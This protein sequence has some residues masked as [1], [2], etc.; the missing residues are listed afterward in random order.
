MLRRSPAQRKPGTDRRPSRERLPRAALVDE[1]N[2]LAGEA[3][4]LYRAAEMPAELASVEM[5]LA[6][7]YSN[8]GD[9]EWADE[10][11]AD[12]E[13][14]L[15]AIEPAPHVTALKSFVR[16]RRLM[17][18]D[19]FDYADDAFR[20]AAEQLEAAEV[21]VQL[22]HALR[23]LGRLAVL[24]GDNDAAID[25]IERAL[26]GARSLGLSGFANVL[27]LDLAETLGTRGELDRRATRSVIA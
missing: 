4:A 19:A 1:V 25:A 27:M 7:T 9:S 23:Y 20:A 18:A 2:E 24:R 12:A 5:A 15:A 16:A 8:R 26:T 14:L 3:I 6:V 13:T 21:E 10:L 11:L 17:V 22:A